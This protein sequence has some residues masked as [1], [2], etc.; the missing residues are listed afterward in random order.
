M[1]DDGWE[2]RMAE[3]AAQ[4]SV[5][6]AAIEAE[7]NQRDWEAFRA[8]LD[9]SH[10]LTLGEAV[11]RLRGAGHWCACVGPPYC[12]IDMHKQASRLQRAAHIVAKL[13]ADR[14]VT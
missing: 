14:P 13:L 7:V 12:C 2:Q 10:E 1:N 9:R 4:R 3:R 11:G 8:Q 6:R 5:Q